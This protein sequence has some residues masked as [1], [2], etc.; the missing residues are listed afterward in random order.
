MCPQVH[1]D[2]FI[3]EFEKQY[4]EFPWRSVQVSPGQSCGGRGFPR[5]LV[6]SGRWGSCVFGVVLPLPLRLVKETACAAALLQLGL[7]G[8]PGGDGEHCRDTQMA[9]GSTCPRS[10]RPEGT[11]GTQLETQAGPHILE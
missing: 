6:A 11:A 2:E 5:G 4:P 7:A 1:Y 8:C 9:V 10:C 3:P